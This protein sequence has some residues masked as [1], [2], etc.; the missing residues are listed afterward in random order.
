MEDLVSFCMNASRCVRHEISRH[1]RMIIID[2][3]IQY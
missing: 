3:I 2:V 1:F